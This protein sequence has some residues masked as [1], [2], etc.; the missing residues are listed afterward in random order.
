M[1]AW[2]PVAAETPM[3]TLLDGLQKQ[4]RT[5]WEKLIGESRGLDREQLNDVLKRALQLQR[6]GQDA[7]AWALMGAADYVDWVLAG[8]DVYV[9]VGQLALIKS[10]QRANQ[11]KLAIVYAQELVREHPDSPTAACRVG[12]LFLTSGK[13]SEAGALLRQ[14]V[15]LA[16]NWAEARLWLGEYHLMMGDAESALSC[17]RQTLQ[18]DPKNAIAADA[19]RLLQS[20]SQVTS[21]HPQALKYF[22]Q[23]EKLFDQGQ[24][25]EAIPLYEKALKADP[26]FAKARIYQGDAYLKLGSADQAIECYRQACKID[27]RDRQGFRFLGD[28]LERRFD[29][30]GSLN[31]IAEAV[32]VYEK[33]VELDPN[34]LMAR[35]DL[36]RARKKLAAARANSK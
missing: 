18:I 22:D 23:A 34:Y 27:P 12:A 13:K 35:E 1:L 33:A 5:S 4:P 32:S 11:E 15:E 24:Y 14:A 7:Q 2:T 8:K 21:S 17:F 9:A 6:D 20:Q 29:D 28:A 19:L 16:P 10:W 25:R 3:D 30:K 26:K 31:D 36:E